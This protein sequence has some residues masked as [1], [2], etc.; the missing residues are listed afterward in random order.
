MAG[1]GLGEFAGAFGQAFTESRRF[2][3]TQKEKKKFA[4]LQA[5]LV[6]MQLNQ[7][8]NVADAQQRVSD[9]MSGQVG[10]SPTT[11]SPGGRT[12]PN[13]VA[14][15]E[16]QVGEFT[17]G[18]DAVAPMDLTQMLADPEGV[19]ALLASKDLDIGDVLK[20]QGMA[21]GRSQTQGLL[22]LLTGGGTGGGAGGFVPTGGSISSKGPQIDFGL[23]PRNAPL[24]AED[25]GL[26][27]NA[28]NGEPA[29]PGQTAQQYESGGFITQPIF[30]ARQNR[31]AIQSD[32]VTDLKNAQDIVRLQKELFKFAP[33]LAP[34]QPAP[35]L[36]RAL[37]GGFAA[38]KDLF[39][40]DTAKARKY[41]AARDELQKKMSI[42]VLS[43]IS[44]FR[45]IGTVTDVKFDQINKSNPNMQ[46]EGAANEKIIAGQL[47]ELI[48]EA[49][50]TGVP[51]SN[52]A[53]IEKFISDLEGGGSTPQAVD[54]ASPTVLDDSVAAIK[55]MTIEQANNLKAKL[56]EIQNSPEAQQLLVEVEGRIAELSDAVSNV[57]TYDAKGNR[58]E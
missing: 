44:R 18:R 2:A 57:I 19:A 41:M 49:D 25:S 22:D 3:D 13:F 1:Q 55:Q 31:K 7:A 11:T 47:R 54:P 15:P 35:E 29:P 53:D 33:H 30:D 6:E 8:E 36:A 34:G 46:I 43:S 42:G 4:K 17:R 20:E 27:V 58:V 16:G 40:G 51:L 23:D 56:S 39:D 38:V 37:A 12:S 21:A 9:M 14:P 28:T 26:Y 45:D 50:R 24:T 5:Q 48:V 32:A 52:R 10:I